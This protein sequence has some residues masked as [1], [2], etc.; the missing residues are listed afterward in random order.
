[1]DERS[2]ADTVNETPVIFFLDIL[3]ALENLG[4]YFDYLDP[5][6]QYNVTPYVNVAILDSCGCKD[7]YLTQN[8]FTLYLTILQYA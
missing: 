4:G 2:V 1:M 5:P 6:A 7:F 3:T 8:E